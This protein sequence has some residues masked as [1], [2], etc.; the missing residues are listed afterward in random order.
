MRAVEFE[1]DA[2]ASTVELEQGGNEDGVGDGDNSAE[3]GEKED[4]VQASHNLQHALATD[5]L[6]SL[7]KTKAQLEKDILDLGKQR[8]SKGFEHDKVLSSIVKEK[9]APKKKLK[10]AQKPG[11]KQEKRVKT[12]SFDEDADFDAVLDAASTGFVETVSSIDL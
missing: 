4:H 2:V 12:V 3:L 11:K 5:R 6:Q 7:K 8:P 1:I 9:P 10:E